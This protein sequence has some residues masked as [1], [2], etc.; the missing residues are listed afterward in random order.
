MKYTCD[1]CIKV[2][3]VPCK[4][5]YHEGISCQEHQKLMV[6]RRDEELLKENLGLLPIKQCPKCT[7]LIERIAG[8]N[9]MKCTQCGIAFCWLCYATDPVDGKFNFTIFYYI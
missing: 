4:T 3:C 2:Y 7:V 8:C 5:E 9:A 1:Q 6:K